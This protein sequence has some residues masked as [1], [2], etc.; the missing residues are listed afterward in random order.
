MPNRRGGLARLGH[1]L[2][3]DKANVLFVNKKNQK[4][5]AILAWRLRRLT[6]ARGG[7]EY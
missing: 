4:N 6:H 3:L 5:F 2:N 7:Q 1:G